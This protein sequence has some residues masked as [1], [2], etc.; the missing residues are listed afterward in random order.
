MFTKCIIIIGLLQITHFNNSDITNLTITSNYTKT[1]WF[2]PGSGS[3]LDLCAIIIL[4]I[5]HA[6]R[7]KASCHGLEHGGG[8]GSQE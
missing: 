4:D 8:P 1:K 2:T 3:Y 6:S 5:H 7:R